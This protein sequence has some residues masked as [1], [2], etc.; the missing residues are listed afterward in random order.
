MKNKIVVITGAS[1]GIGKALAFEFANRGAKIVLA[2]RNTE[3]LKVIESN[4]RN[5]GVEVLSV[6]TDVR[7][8]G[9]CE[10]L[11]HK[12][13]QHFGGIDILINN[14]GISMR[15]LFAEL[16]LSI[17]KQLM[18]VNFWGTVFCTKYALP[19]IT[20]AKGSVVGVIS[21]AGYIGLPARSGYS[22]SKY[23]IRGFLDTLRV[24]NLKTGVHVLV[25]APGFTASNVRNVALIAD[26]ST[27]GETPRDESKMMSA[28]ECARLIA[29]A[30]KKR[31]RELIM[32]FVEGKFTVW[33]KKWFPSL[34]EKL[35]YQ[36]MAKE[37][38]SPLK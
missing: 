5:R 14:A 12:A 10:N 30:V 36:H 38:N 22:A 33:L 19:F 35:T 31:K 32:T 20:K 6:T 16:D 4:I 3:K 24:E 8:E 2:A 1:S 28:E 7:I 13:V 25:A 23:A 34:L 17:I 18:D 37:P 11:M 29:N 26:G 27:Q 21:I 9:D 15:A